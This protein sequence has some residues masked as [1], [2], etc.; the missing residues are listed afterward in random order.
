ML[1]ND[2]PGQSNT[3]VEE[4]IYYAV[5]QLSSAG[6]TPQTLPNSEDDDI[7]DYFSQGKNA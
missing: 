1:C 7:T 5:V 2:C 3:L 6:R 4:I